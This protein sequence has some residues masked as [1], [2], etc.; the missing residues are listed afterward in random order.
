MTWL[1]TNDDGFDAEGLTALIASL[2]P[3]CDYL[4]VAPAKQASECSHSVTTGRPLEITQHAE[5]IFSVDGTPVDCV[6]V[7]QNIL[8]EQIDVV[9]SGINHGANLGVD[10]HLSG[11]VAAAREAALHGIPAVAISQYRHPSAKL[12]WSL[13]PQWLRCD[14][15]RLIQDRE[16]QILNDHP[17]R[18]GFYNINLPAIP[19]NNPPT[20]IHSTTDSLPLPMRFEKVGNQAIY[21]GDYH[22]RTRVQGTDIDACFGGNISVS[23]V[24]IE[25]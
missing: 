5:R 7:A 20:W 11:T 23:F 1:I 4:V 10:I 19:K 16:R 24:A 9:L 8:I 18:R 22:N 2:P 13:P 3:E 17:Q 25:P 12:D 14:L 6:R 21:G 15:E